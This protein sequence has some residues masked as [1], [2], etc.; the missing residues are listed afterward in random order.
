VT[1]RR[2]PNGL[3]IDAQ[4]YNEKG[5]LVG[6]LQDNKY[7]IVLQDGSTLNRPDLSTI[8]V[9]DARKNERLW[10]RYLNKA[11]VQVRGALIARDRRPTL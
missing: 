4:I 5:A 1:I 10:V 2:K 7:D 3:S 8:G 9:T 6:N 11:A